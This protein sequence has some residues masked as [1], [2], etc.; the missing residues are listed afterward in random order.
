MGGGCCAHKLGI[1]HRDLKV[2]DWLR[3]WRRRGGVSGGGCCAHK[4]GI[5]HR[6]LKVIKPEGTSLES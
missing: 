4:L 5:M 2:V 3:S 6:D 1:V